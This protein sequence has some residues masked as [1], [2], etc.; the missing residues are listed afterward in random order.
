MNERIKQIEHQM[1]SME[2]AYDDLMTN[3]KDEYDA[4]YQELI[5]LQRKESA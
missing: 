1:Y 5:E 4:L 3:H 2:C